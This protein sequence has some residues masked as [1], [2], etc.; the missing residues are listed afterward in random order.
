ME[1]IYGYLERVTYYNE[2]N[3][4]MVARLKEKGARELTTIVGN[5]AGI[6]PGESLQLLGKWVHNKQHGRQFLVEKFETRVPA[7]VNGIEKYL[8]C[9]LIK[10]IGP[11]MAKRIVKLFQLDTLEVIEDSPQGCWKWK[12]LAKS[13]WR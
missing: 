5:L 9:G 10:G 6:N 8:G 11:V 13:G 12:G 3:S 7:T 4:F 2:E 1:T